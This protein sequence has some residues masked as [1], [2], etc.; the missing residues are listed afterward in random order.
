MGIRLE[1]LAKLMQFCYG[2]GPEVTLENSCCRAEG[3]E[4]IGEYRDIICGINKVWSSAVGV[5]LELRSGSRGCVCRR[6]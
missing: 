3:S 2:R 4:S 1:V 5:D 6:M